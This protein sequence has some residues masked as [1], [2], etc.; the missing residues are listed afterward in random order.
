MAT[1]DYIDKKEFY[2]Q[3]CEYKQKVYA[4]KEAG[5]PK[6]QITNYL[7]QCVMDIAE[8]LSHDTKYAGYTFRSDMIGDAIENCIMYFNNFD[9]VL[10]KDP[11]AYFTQ[12]CKYAFWRRIMKEKKLLYVKYKI[13]QQSSLMEEDLKEEIEEGLVVPNQLYD[14]ITEFIKEYESNEQK[15]KDKAKEKAKAKAQPKANTKSQLDDFME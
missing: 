3:I 1:V 11:F 14:N 4:A 2:K 9:E 5:A 10:Y 15:R 7:C 12:I 13:A 6:P 8:N